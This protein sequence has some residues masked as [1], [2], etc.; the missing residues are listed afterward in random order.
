MSNLLVE[1]KNMNFAILSNRPAEREKNKTL[2]KNV[3]RR[4]FIREASNWEELETILDKN[5]TNMLVIDWLHNQENISKL[6]TLILKYCFIRII[7]ISEN[8]PNQCAIELFT[9]GIYAVIPQLLEYRQIAN[10][11]QLVALGGR[12]ISPEFLNLDY[13]IKQNKSFK[14]SEPITQINQHPIE[15]EF[16]KFTSLSKRQKEIMS[17]L[18]VGST[19]KYIARSFD[20]SE[21]TVKTH[22]GAILKILCVP[23]R[24]AAASVYNAR[25]NYLKNKN[26]WLDTNF[27]LYAN[28]PL[29]NNS[30]QNDYNPLTNLE[31]IS[32]TSSNSNI[33]MNANTDTDTDADTNTNKLPQ[34]FKKNNLSISNND[35][36]LDYQIKEMQKLVFAKCNQADTNNSAN[37]VETV[38]ITGKSTCKLNNDYCSKKSSVIS[39]LAIANAKKTLYSP[40]KPWKQNRIFNHHAKMINGISGINSNIAIKPDN[41]LVNL[42][43]YQKI[44]KNFK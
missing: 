24:T 29:Q 32:R 39:R 25:K 42:M 17:L 16:N 40:S 18:S 26:D 9:R 7:I 5:I 21:G 4:A 6:N 35:F 2:L 38:D 31:T 1:G 3:S 36:H 14:V 8:L 20:I 22:I 41:S 33:N 43:N 13:K 11:L 37:L 10:I 30:L 34:N 27:D 28:S 19:N 23:N 15:N 44:N 12:Y